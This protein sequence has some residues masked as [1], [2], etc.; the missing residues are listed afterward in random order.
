MASSIKALSSTVRVIG[1]TCDSVPCAE[2]G[3]SGPRATIAQR[4]VAGEAPRMTSLLDDVLG[5]LL[6][7]AEFRKAVRVK[8]GGL[9][10]TMKRAELTQLLVSSW[11]PGPAEKV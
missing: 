1:P 8:V 9:V 3:Q 7:S 5:E 4:A 2:G 6:A 11:A 10:G